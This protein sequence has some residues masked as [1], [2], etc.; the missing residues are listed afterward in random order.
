VAGS[1]LVAPRNRAISERLAEQL[2]EVERLFA[3]ELHSDL[4]CVNDLVGHIEQYRGK[5]LRPMLVLVT[6]M[7]CS[8]DRLELTDGHR[9]IAGV[10]EMVHMATLVHDDVLDEAD[11]RRGGTTINHL[12]GNETAVMLG[13]FLISHAY[14]LCSSLDDPTVSKIMANATNRVCEGE[15]Q[16]LANRNNWLLDEETYYQIIGGKTAYLCGTCC[17]LGALLCA[18]PDAAV[19]AM[20]DYGQKLGLAFQIVDDLLDLTGNEDTVGK[21]LGLDLQKGKLTLPLIHLLASSDATQRDELRGLLERIVKQATLDG[22][23]VRE[24]RARIV[25]GGSVEYANTVARRLV[26][27]AKQGLKVLAESPARSLLD[28]MADAVLTRKF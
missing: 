21:T 20:D 15:M 2:K 6:G 28:E 26:D 7:A 24:I 14:H 22:D 23:A 27:E 3:A 8:P 12:R 11:V 25:A 4:A 16:Q 13:D 17:R 9:T 19:K 1:L 5:M 18:S 10:V